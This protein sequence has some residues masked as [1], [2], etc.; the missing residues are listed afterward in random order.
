MIAI[1]ANVIVRLLT[2]DDEGQYQ[3]A[4][5]LFEREQVF[6]PTTVILETEW[7]LSYAY[8]F[9][10]EQIINAFRA[11]FGLSNVDLE[12]PLLVAEALDWRAQGMDFV[13]SLH[14]AAS[15]QADRFVT[16]DKKLIG[17]VS[18]LIDFPVSQP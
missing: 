4:Y 16:F 17:K 7:V 12:H 2:K 5:G 9:K 18:S 15:K 10:P 3:A 13:D 1:D 6:I 8:R 14:V 11:L